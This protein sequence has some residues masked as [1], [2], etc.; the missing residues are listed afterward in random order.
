MV[1]DLLSIEGDGHISPIFGKADGRRR[2]QRDALVR[3][4][5]QLIKVDPRSR[6]RLRVELPKPKQGGTIVEQ[7]GVEEIR[8]RPAGLGD[9]LAESQHV[10]RQRELDKFLP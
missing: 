8:R 6:D 3:G 9:E 2:D 1:L 4:A 5:E 7:A 10:L